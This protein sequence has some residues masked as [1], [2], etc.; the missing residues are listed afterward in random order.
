MAGKGPRYRFRAAALCALA[1]CA[2]C[3]H[4]APYQRPT[5][6][7]RGASEPYEFPGFT[8]VAPQGPDWFAVPIDEAA[9]GAKDSSVIIF[10]RR[11]AQAPTSDPASVHNARVAFTTRY[12]G[13]GR[14]E[15]LREFLASERSRLS[16]LLA[17]PD[18]PRRRLREFQVDVAGEMPGCLRYA[19]KAEG[20]YLE[21]FPG[22]PFV[23]T[24]RSYQCLVA[25]WPTYTVSATYTE[26]FRE[27]VAPF[28][29]DRE[30]EPSLRSL[31]LTGERP[32]FV[33]PIAI[34][35]GGQ[36]VSV[37]AGSVWVAYGDHGVA[38]V[39]ARTNSV[40]QIEV[41]KDP[42]GIA[43][44]P[45]GIW[46]ANRKDATVSRIDP[47][48]NRVAMTVPAGR[49]P[50]T[51]AVGGGA[52]WV[53]DNGT[54]SV[55]RLDPAGHGVAR[56]GVD[57]RSRG[58]AAAAGGVYVASYGRD[59][60][61]RIDPATNAVAATVKLQR[62]TMNSQPL[63]LE[64]IA[65]DEQ[66]VWVAASLEGTVYR[67]D[68]SDLHVV[69]KIPLDTRTSGIAIGG[70]AVWVTLYD[71]FLVAKIDPRTNQLTGEPIP[72]GVRPVL[73]G[74]GEGAL[75]VTNAFSRNLSRIDP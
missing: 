34:G 15:D 59:S 49:E 55:L 64:G 51:I 47:E 60:V 58:I 26:E 50:W 17:T 41:G 9:P 61:L 68:P 8:F 43:A 73:A 74:W 21:E 62:T 38:R 67:L 46:V 57:Y 70:G 53:V 39:D 29:V 30:V 14:I 22:V 11:P 71:D 72:V 18:D 40:V 44:G 19:E 42:I 1:A 54:T 5:R 75:W 36:G 6:P 66:G 32:V 69:A 16:Q 33:T 23:V 37:F 35:P 25:G 3:A 52:V 12:H 4:R 2:S 31:R 10:A 48:T 13:G 63:G 28:P 20:T 65:A 27:G 45:E 56:I 7:V 24:I